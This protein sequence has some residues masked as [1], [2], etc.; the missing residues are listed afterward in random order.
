M[1]IQ[2]EI[3]FALPDLQEYEQLIVN[4][5]CTVTEALSQSQIVIQHQLTAP[6]HASIFGKLAKPSQALREGDRIEILRPLVGDPKEIR[7]RRVQNG[8]TMGKKKTG[9]S[10]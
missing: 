9:N 4:A 3:V 5:D 6:I 1:S 7:R 10:E 8:Q 2:V